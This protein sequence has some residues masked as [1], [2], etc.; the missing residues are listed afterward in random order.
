[1]LM[2]ELLP[3]WKLKKLR[4]RFITTR[5]NNKLTHTQNTKNIKLSYIFNKNL[6]K[7]QIREQIKIFP[8]N[9]VVYKNN[10]LNEMKKKLYHDLLHSSTLHKWSSEFIKKDT[11]GTLKISNYSRAIIKKWRRNHLTAFNEIFKF[12]EEIKIIII[13][14][15]GLKNAK[16]RKYHNRV[17]YFTQIP[18]FVSDFRLHLVYAYICELN[19]NKRINLHSNIYKSIK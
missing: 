18:L 17:R 11:F 13:M 12:R 8:E 6:F 4:Y 1:M 19:S 16:K 3:L 2:K 10:I 5:R 9:T 14:L 7:Y 15:L